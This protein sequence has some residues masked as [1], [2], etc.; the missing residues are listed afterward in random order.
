[1]ENHAKFD[2][3]IHETQNENQNNS[4]ESQRQRTCP[5]LQKK[6]TLPPSGLE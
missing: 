6:T 5:E 3:K 1:M 2:G 4:A